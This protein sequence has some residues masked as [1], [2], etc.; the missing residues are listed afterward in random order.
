MTIRARASEQQVDRFVT[1][2]PVQGE[3]QQ[4]GEQQSWGCRQ[5]ADLRPVYGIP[6]QA[7]HGI[8]RSQSAAQYAKFDQSGHP[9]RDGRVV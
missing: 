2:Q 8:D 6:C 5:V 7:Q 1:V 3:A 4:H 9:W